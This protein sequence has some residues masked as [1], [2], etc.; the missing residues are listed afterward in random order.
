MLPEVLSGAGA[1]NTG[2]EIRRETMRRAGLTILKFL[3][4]IFA[5]FAFAVGNA[6]EVQDINFV[7]FVALECLFWALTGITGYAVWRYDNEE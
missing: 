6:H 4:V 7:T 5:I 2:A 1:R 3:T